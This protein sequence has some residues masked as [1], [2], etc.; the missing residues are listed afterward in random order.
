M[1]LAAGGSDVAW[2][3]RGCGGLHEVLRPELGAFGG[4][5]APIRMVA[6]PG[7]GVALEG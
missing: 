1:C 2:V 7:D 6:W 5:C 3:K 4:D